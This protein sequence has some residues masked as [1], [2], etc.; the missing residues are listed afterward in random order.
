MPTFFKDAR[1][2]VIGNVREETSRRG[3]SDAKG[4]PVAWVRKDS[5][6]RETTFDARGRLVGNGDQG[7]RMMK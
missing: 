2:R 6:S 3:Y 7:L 4:M 5:T 1:G